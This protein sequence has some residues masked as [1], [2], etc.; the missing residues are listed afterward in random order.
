METIIINL[1]VIIFIVVV[2]LFLKAT[3]NNSEPVII[4][5][6]N[7]TIHGQVKGNESK[8]HK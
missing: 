8:C 5:F 7:L 4:K 6:E 1:S 3:N 2:A